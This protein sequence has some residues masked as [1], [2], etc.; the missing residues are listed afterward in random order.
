MIV[1]LILADGIYAQVAYSVLAT[2]VAFFWLTWPNRVPK[3]V[4]GPAKN[5][6]YFGPLFEMLRNFDRLP[7]YCVEALH[8][9]DGKTWVVPM[10]KFGML[11]GS[12]TFLTTPEVRENF[13]VDVTLKNLSCTRVPL[14]MSTLSLFVTSML[15]ARDQRV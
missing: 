1:S 7:D 11:R 6:P 9:Y 4:P 8:L 12:V 3:D 13:F 10:P 15:F 14:N 2:V 5:L